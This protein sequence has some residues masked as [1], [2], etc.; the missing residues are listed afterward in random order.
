VIDQKSP[1]LAKTPAA[2]L[3]AASEFG[4]LLPPLVDLSRVCPK[5]V[6]SVEKVHRSA[7]GAPGWDSA[8]DDMNRGAKI[9]PVRIYVNAVKAA[10]GKD[11]G[12]MP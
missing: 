9:P 7:A 8:L 4:V 11:F 12:V 1:V 5:P 6:T 3:C 10:T 2:P